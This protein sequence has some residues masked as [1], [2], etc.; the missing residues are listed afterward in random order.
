MVEPN[1]VV[2]IDNGSGYMKAGLASTEAPSCVFPAVIGRPK[3][4]QTM[5]SAADSRDYFVGDDAMAKKGVLS[6][7][8][9]IEH[10]IVKDWNDMEKVWNH[11]F[12]DQLRVNPEDRPV[13]V[14]EAPMNPK[15]NRERMMEMLFDK[16]SVPATWVA[17]Q[18]V[19]SLYS[20]GRTTGVVVDSGDGVTHVVPVYEGFALPHAVQRMDLAG[21]DLSDYMVKILS[22]TG[23]SMVSS[24]EQQ[25]VRDMKEK[26]CY[27]PLEN[28]QEESRKNASEYEMTYELPDGN[29][30]YLKEERF[31][32][33]EIMFDP[34]ICGRELPGL[35]ES[36]FKCVQACDVDLRRDLYKNIVLSGGNTLFP[37]IEVRL[38][39][40]VKAL[41]PQKIDVRVSASPQRRYLVWMGASVLSQLSSFENMLITKAEYDEIGSNIVHQKCF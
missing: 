31:R 23:I 22:E 27:V 3:H 6:L 38:Q 14:T 1:D 35:H 34:M 8:Y 26:T 7:S 15:K 30:V 17:I 12:F 33:P 13:I 18:A 9:P 10:G 29:K 16:F 41:A 32:V 40:E 5:G 11:T 37:N 4:G 39:N 20:Y 28:L 2:V 19:M 36:V 24:A 21:R 25:I